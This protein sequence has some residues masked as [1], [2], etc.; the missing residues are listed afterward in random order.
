MLMTIGL[1]NHVHNLCHGAFGYGEDADHMSYVRVVM[2]SVACV[3]AWDLLA[4]PT[5]FGF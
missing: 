2:E 1:R 5:T 4:P 3:V